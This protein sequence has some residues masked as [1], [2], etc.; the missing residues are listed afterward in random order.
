MKQTNNSYRTLGVM[1]DMSRNA[2]MSLDGLKRFLPLLKK[3]GYNCVMLYT[4]D[5]YEV[6]NEPYFGYMRGRYTKEEM[7]EI[8]AFAASLGISV[9]PCIQTLAHLNAIFRWKKF[10]H[11]C[12]DILLTDDERTYE[13]IEN[14]L[15]TLSECFTSRKIHIGMDEANMLGRGKHLD[16]HGYETV[17]AIMK[18]HLERI[19]EIAKKYDYELMV[20]SDMFFRPWNN[21]EYVIPKKE[22]PKEVIDSLP[23]SVIPVYWDY[24]QSKISV[25]DDMLE[26][27]KQLSDKTWFAGGAWSWLGFVPFNQFTLK[28][29]IPALHACKE[30]Q[31][32][33]IIFTMWG[34]DGAECSHFSQLPSLFYL[35][36]YA[37]G[38][39]DEASIKAK[40]KK[41]CGIDFDEFMQIDCPNNII[42]HNGM[43]ANP[44]KYMLY[45]DCFNDYLDYTVTEG[46]GEKYKEYAKALHETARKSLKYRYVFDT[47]AK[48]CEVLEIKYEL[49]LRTRKAYEVGDKTE[50]KRLAENEYTEV[51]KRLLV[52]I[53]AFEKQWMRDNKPHGF[54]VQE[55][56]L[57]AL[58][59]RIDSCRRR[60][61][62]YANGKI[63]R[64]EELDE[65]LL[66]Y[67]KKNSIFQFNQAPITTTVNTIHHNHN[68]PTE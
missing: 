63:N 62:S 34:D 16:K 53:R 47:A 29:M 46:A 39:T 2:V 23:S 9:I 5:T 35:A 7:K 25:Y 6:D 65:K 48:L 18:R 68:S 56:R 44:S 67:K 32:K 58:L 11:D 41:F 30:H 54:D 40:F 12:D 24:Y 27:H 33:D 36:E 28:T 17:N 66:P 43:P 49:G 20:W 64:I 57:G 15:S 50:L 31:I 19:C 26:N 52:F 10:P 13:L 60:I 1:I 14:M 3:M 38:N 22:I 45:S 37:K 61:L 55:M 42:E 51:R 21:G 4:E 8:D 59:Y